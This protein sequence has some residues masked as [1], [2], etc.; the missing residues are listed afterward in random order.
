M[1]TGRLMKPYQIYQ[2]S[3]WIII[4]ILI[5]SNIILSVIL[6]KT[7]P[8]FKLIAIEEGRTRWVSE[9]HDDVLKAEEERFVKM[10]I[11]KYFSRTKESISDFKES[12]F[13]LEEKFYKENE[14]LIKELI[15]KIEAQEFEE[16]IHILQMSIEEGEYKII[17]EKEQLQ[18][19][20][21]TTS[22][23]IV[24]LE[25][26][27]VP[28]SETAPWGILVKSIREEGAP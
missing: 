7:K 20:D 19:G 25:L 8:Q 17:L 12:L 28:R 15:V 26:M 3:L 11:K 21:K 16:R 13:Y 4:V 2:S 23:R 24:K 10:F 1:K 14:I 5:F 18:R 27:R 9:N 6:I 22:K